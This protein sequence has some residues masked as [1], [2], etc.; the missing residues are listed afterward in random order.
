MK[1]ALSWHDHITINIHWFG[2]NVVTGVITPILLPALI[3]LTVPEA[4]KNSYLGTVRVISLATAM[5]LQP[6]AGM[7]SD[8]NTSRWGRR[9]PFILLGTVLD[10]LF[11]LMIASVPLF[12]GS[13]LDSFFQPTF[14]VT[15]AFT[16]L[17]GS[18]VLLQIA[19][20]TA[21]GA[22]QGLIP[23]LVP[24]NQ[25]GRSSG[26]KAV[27]EL[28]P[29]FP[30]IFIGPLVDGGRYGL[31]VAIIAAA[32]LVTTFITLAFVREEPLV[33]GNK[34]NA[35][36]AILR[37]VALTAIFV[38][39]TRVAV[40]LV[41]LSSGYLSGQN[42]AIPLQVGLVGLAGLIGMAGAILVG[43][44]AGAWVGIGREARQQRSF[45]WWVVNRLMFLAAIGSIQVFALYFLRDVLHIE[46]AATV[47][48]YL[49]GLVGVFL[50]A[51]AL[52]GGA[53]ADRIGRKK[54]IAV[55]GLVAAG[56][57]VLLLF[58]TTVPFVLVC[59]CI[60]GAATGT[61]YA[62]NWALGTDIAPPQEAGRYLGISNLAGAGAGIIGA[63]IGGPL[64]DF[65]NN[66]QPGLG[67]LVLFAIYAALF[68]LSAL[69]LTQ[70]KT[71]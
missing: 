23:D 38:A 47:T 31:T 26:V 69:T 56:G 10:L 11:L 42:L 39:A 27:M 13:A 51:A 40:W 68:L 6:V 65:F 21:Q 30:I 18:V 66:L 41:N 53:L 36:R 3:L 67:Y 15:T 70:I 4:Q 54:L 34:E 12:L 35:W 2:L 25:R 22:L 1:K 46:N 64:A 24:E 71:T 43:V 37:L 17:L 16:V 33:E 19:A 52:G 61:F 48:S 63:G 7:L 62:T 44:Y 29:A 32:L 50:I 59:G 28:L 9:R 58:A 45:I 55:S 8:R 57:T 20:N 5:L 60:L 14:G 49:L